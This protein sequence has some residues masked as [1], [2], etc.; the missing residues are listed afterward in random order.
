MKVWI[1]CEEDEEQTQAP[2][3]TG[4]VFTDEAKAK[5]YVEAVNADPK[6][7]LFLT[8]VEGELM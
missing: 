2:T 6:V 4:E 3:P 5:A 7:L 1:V 8:L